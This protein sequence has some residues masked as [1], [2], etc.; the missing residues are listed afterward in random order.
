MPIRK[1]VRTWLSPQDRLAE[2]ICGI[3]MVLSVTAYTRA[4]MEEPSST[5]FLVA[6]LGCNAAWGLV[7]GGTYV[8]GSIQTR[9]RR[10]MIRRS[11][12]GATGP[13]QAERHAREVMEEALGEWLPEGER[14][15]RVVAWAIEAARAAPPEKP[16]VRKEDLLAGLAC[17]CLMFFGTLPLAAPYLLLRDLDRAILVSQGVAVLMLFLLG[18]Q[19]G[20]LS[21]FRPIRAGLLFTIIGLALSGVTQFLGG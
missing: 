9:G 12:S 18:R 17:F 3:V 19:W 7:D 2:A 20:A 13:V 4:A 10:L 1:F 16:G 21:G 8:F 14:R 15:E 5:A 11:L 6:I